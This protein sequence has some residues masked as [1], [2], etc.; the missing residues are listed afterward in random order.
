MSLLGKAVVASWSEI[1]P[2]VIDDV[3]AWHTREHI[4]ERLAL[5]GFL[6]ARRC[7]G[8]DDP[9]A[10]FILYE[11]ETLAALTTPAYLA[12]LN[13]PTDWTRRSIV[14]LRHSVRGVGQVAASSGYAA[15][16]FV[17][18]IRMTAV[19]RPLLDRIMRRN[20]ESPA[21]LGVHLCIADLSASII[22]TAERKLHPVSTPDQFFIVEAIDLAALHA[23]V[24]DIL[25]ALET[26][27]RKHFFRVELLA[28][29]PAAQLG[30]RFS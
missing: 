25:A 7:A 24:D 22:K 9:G 10:W 19:D 23:F 5:P 15:G 4:P 12:R 27:A 21:I 3:R 30:L 2:A 29:A 20:I 14:H 8:V 6:R 1:D 28:T 26:H 13:A 11:A 16:G 17:A 18:T